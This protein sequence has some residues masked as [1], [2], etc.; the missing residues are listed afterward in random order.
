ML[1]QEKKMDYGYDLKIFIVI[2]AHKTPL[3]FFI[4]NSISITIKPAN[5]KNHI[6]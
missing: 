5:I 1:N 3:F 2:N 4:H 6:L